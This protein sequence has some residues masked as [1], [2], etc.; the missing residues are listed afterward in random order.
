MTA[1]QNTFPVADQDLGAYYVLNVGRRLVVNVPPL[2]EG[3]RLS[4]DLQQ[5]AVSPRRYCFSPTIVDGK[6]VS[7]KMV[8]H[9]DGFHVQPFAWR[10]CPMRYSPSTS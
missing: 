4:D 7:V 10:D 1:D 2:A 5:A 8:E 3:Q 9:P 6:I